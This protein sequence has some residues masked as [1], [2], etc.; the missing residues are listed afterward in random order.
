MFGLQSCIRLVMF[1]YFSS[2]SAQC[3]MNVVRSNSND[4]SNNNEGACVAASFLVCCFLGGCFGSTYRLGVVGITCFC[5]KVCFSTTKPPTPLTG[6]SPTKVVVIQS[7]S[8]IFVVNSVV[9]FCQ[10]MWIT[11]TCA[12]LNSKLPTTKVRKFNHQLWTTARKNQLFPSS[13][14]RNHTWIHPKLMVSWWISNSYLHT[15][16][17]SFDVHWTH[18]KKYA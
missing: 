2:L 17:M 7:Q 6:L 13:H 18:V 4:V 9:R 12:G 5:V 14:P 3:L 11:R 10:C 8:W 1:S 15:W 16:W